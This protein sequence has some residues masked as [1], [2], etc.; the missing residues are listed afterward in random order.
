MGDIEAKSPPTQDVASLLQRAWTFRR[1]LLELDDL[2]D[3]ILSDSNSVMEI[4]STSS[5]SSL[6][7]CY[8]FSSGLITQALL[9]YW[10]LIIIIDNIIQTLSAKAGI[11]NN[12]LKELQVSSIHAADQ[13]AMSAEQARHSVPIV[14]TLHG[15]SLPAAIAAY[16]NWEFRPWKSNDEIQWLK[17]G[18]RDCLAPMSSAMRSIMVKYFGA[19]G[20]PRSCVS[21]PAEIETAKA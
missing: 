16:S 19:V 7:I 18:L 5:D 1:Q 4:P 14:S 10:R 8:H 3:Q 21:L 15:F 13:I 12:S 6:Q 17:E 20:L 2:V 11:S 9:L